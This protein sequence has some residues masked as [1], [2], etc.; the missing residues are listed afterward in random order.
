VQPDATP[1]ATA[2]CYLHPDRP[3]GS[4]CRRCNQP[5]CPDCM[6]EAPVGWQCTRC[7]HQDSRRAPVTR[8]RPAPTTAGRL[9]NT[10]LT[11][12][13]IALIAVNVIVF[14][15][16]ES[17]HAGYY[18][19]NVGSGPCANVVQCRFALWPRAVHHG[20]WYRL[21]TAAFLHANIEHIGLNMVT[22]AIVGS[23]VEAELGKVRFV[24]LYLVAAIGGSVA[25]YL[26]SPQDQFG[27]GA[28]GAIFGLMGA[29]FVLA[30]RNRWD[31]RT[32]AVLIVI[33]LLFDFSTTTID[34]RAHIG[35]LIAGAAVAWGLTEST[36]LRPRVS[37]ATELAAE[38]TSVLGVAIVFGL[39]V[40]LPPGHVNLS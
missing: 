1:P 3:A 25:S 2:T 7:V 28:S 31:A 14:I 4:V 38:V 11:P 37:R 35:G 17:S 33:N 15:W 13:V 9:G 18:I 5:I 26:L 6:R 23:P 40:L 34:W 12:V 10:R 24:A 39:L 36:R 30:R 19:S 27:L 8:W 29:Y 22:L 16:E 21:F 20:Q 32:I